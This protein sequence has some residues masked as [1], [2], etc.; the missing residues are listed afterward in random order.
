MVDAYRINLLH[1]EDFGFVEAFKLIDYHE[2]GQVDIIQLKEALEYYLNVVISQR[3]IL[4]L[5]NRYDKDQ[6]E[7]IK[8]SDFCEMIIP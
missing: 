4:L 8:F 6:D 2:L 7:L 1:K 3:E 5:F